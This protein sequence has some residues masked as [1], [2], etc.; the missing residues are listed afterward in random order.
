MELTNR[1]RPFHHIFTPLR[2]L[3]NDSRTTGVF[4]VGCTIISLLITNSS[5]TGWFN[6]FWNDAIPTGL[7]ASLK[8]P[9]FTHRVDQ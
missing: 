6:K 9:G 7:F 2:D 1:K 5:S 8:L 4:L 3:L